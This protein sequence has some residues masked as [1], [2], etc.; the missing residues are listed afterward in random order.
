M[1][2]G[3]LTLACLLLAAGDP[4]SDV[5]PMR[6]RAFDIPIRLDPARKAEIRELQ[7]SVSI[8]QG[9]SWHVVA[10][11]TPDQSVFGYQAPN[12]GEYWFSISVVDQQG[13]RDPPSPY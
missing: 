9:K 4:S 2:M 1:G 5:V 12:D 11:A 6:D 8:D 10:V 7:L 3:T 13:R